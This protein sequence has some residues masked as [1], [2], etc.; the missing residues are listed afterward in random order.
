MPHS[1]MILK[2]EISM[3]SMTDIDSS[4]NKLIRLEFGKFLARTHGENFSND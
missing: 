3:V 1:P 4:L 2:L